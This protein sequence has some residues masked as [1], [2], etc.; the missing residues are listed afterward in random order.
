MESFLIYVNQNSYVDQFTSFF[1]IFYLTLYKTIFFI[2]YHVFTNEAKI[3]CPSFKTQNEWHASRTKDIF[4]HPSFTFITKE[5]TLVMHCIVGNTMKKFWCLS[6]Y[7]KE[8][9]MCV[10]MTVFSYLPH[11]YEDTHKKFE[12][13]V[14][15]HCIYDMVQVL[16]RWC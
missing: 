7:E 13:S 1:N 5:N 9:S 12:H 4:K 10:C 16:D 14:T 11:V 2:Y 8:W 15:N 3:L 6:L